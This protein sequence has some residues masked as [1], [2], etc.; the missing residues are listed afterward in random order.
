MEKFWCNI[1]IYVINLCV[2]RVLFS[3]IE[4][5]SVNAVGRWRAY[6]KGTFNLY[7]EFE[8]TE[9]DHVDHNFAS[10][11]YRLKLAGVFK[12]WVNR[13]RIDV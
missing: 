10:K 5:I 7:D 9:V 13:V 8:E 4:F 3:L 6:T 2:D 11:Y 1:P 12:S